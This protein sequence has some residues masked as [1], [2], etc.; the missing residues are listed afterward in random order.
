MTPLELEEYAR[1]RYNAVDDTFFSSAEIMDYIYHA[2]QELAQESQVIERIYTTTTVASTQAYDFP[3]NAMSFKRVTWNGRKLALIDMR[4]DDAITG[5]NQA[6]TD[7]GDPEV[8]WIWNRAIYLRPIPSSAQTL[9]MWSF[10]FPSEVSTTS[11]LEVPEQFH[12]KLA[13][14]VNQQMAV[15]DQNFIAAKYYG[16]LWE[17][18]K[19]DVK[20][21]MRKLKRGDG[22]SSTKDENMIVETIIS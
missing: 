7:T 20:R 13:N 21:T 15:K 9:K 14:Y 19:L 5:M 12:L 11:T 22:F 10:N 1:R 3:T 16:T 6:T 17:K 2:C 8:Y 4:E 18:D